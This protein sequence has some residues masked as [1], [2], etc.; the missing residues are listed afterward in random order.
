MKEKWN[1]IITAMGDEKVTTNKEYYKTGLICL[2]LGIIIGF[3]IAP[4]KKGIHNGCVTTNNLGDCGCG[5]DCDCDC[6]CEE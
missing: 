3:I 6:D 1:M 2:L 4:I 5:C